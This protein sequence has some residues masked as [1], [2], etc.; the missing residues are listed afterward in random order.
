MSAGSLAPLRYGAFRLLAAGRM[1]SMLGNAVAPIALA[2]AVLDLTGSAGDL[3][4]VVGARSLTNVVFL[5]LGGVI[6]D[7]LPR[8]LVMVVSSAVAAITQA[9]VAAA[10]LTGAATVPLLMVLSA[11]N[12]LA[13][14]LAWPAVSAL[15]PQTV[16]EAIRKQAIAINRIGGNAAMILGAPAGGILVATVGPGWGLAADA[17]TFALSGVCFALIR[18][19][20]VRDH[21][22]KKPSV[23]AGLR[24]GWSEFTSRTWLWV[25]V[26]GFMFLNAAWA[27]SM[28]V[29]GPVVADDTIGRRAWGFV[30]AAQTAG[31]IAGAL[32]AIRI[33]VRRLLAFGVIAVAGMALLPSGLALA[34]VL[35]VL[36]VC[37]FVGGVAFDQ[38]GIAWETTMQEYVPSD[39]LARVY[40]YDMLGSLVAIPVGQVAAGPA[41]HALG[42]RTTL[43]IA[44]GVMLVAV[45]GMLTSRDVRT[46]EH[47]PATEK[48]PA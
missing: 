3:G 12:G 2:F 4:L 16:P 48:A 24:D 23:L 35:W 45:A 21:A 31:M 47:R 22:V 27:A 39:K 9:A 36:V 38:F 8:H 46:L 25:V 43:L 44:V 18:V 1:I 7:R 6:A 13:S 34:P 33:T 32:L 40:S 42:A 41:A 15:L 19:T 28:G 11:I 29:L 5:L 10:V 26:L 20:G 37:A 30:L 14:A 17:A